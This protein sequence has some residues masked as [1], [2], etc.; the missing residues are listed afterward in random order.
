MILRRW[1]ASVRTRLRAAAAERELDDELRTHL[2]MAV[3]ENLAQGM[4]EREAARAAHR[5]L[6]VVSA[7]KEAYHQADSLYW[8]DTLL[9]DLRYGA[10][11]LRRSPRFTGAVVL[12]LGLG[13]GMTTAVFAIVDSVL[14]NAVPFAEPHRLVELYRLGP[15]GGGPG[16]PAAMVESWRNERALFDG[17]EAYVRLERVFTGG[18]EPETMQ[19]ARVSPGLL[20][21]LGVAP[22]LGRAF[23][24]DEAANAVAIVSHSTWLTR[25]GGDADIVGRPLRFTDGVLMIVGVMPASFRFPDA[26]TVFWEPLDVGRQAASGDPGEGRVSVVARLGRDVTFEQADARAAA[27]APQWNREWF[28]TGYTTRLK[29]LNQLAGLG[30]DGQFTWVQQRRAALFL[31][32]GLAA[33]VLLIACAN[34]ANLFLSQAL[35]RTREFAI[36]AAAG[37]GRLRLC[38]QLLTESV[39]V[40]AFAG[41]LG[42]TFA[43][44]LVGLAAAAVPPE[45]GRGV[46][47]PIDVD[48][49]VV[50]WA[51]VAAL[52]AGVAATLPPALR[53]VGRDL[54]RS[55]Q[56]SASDPARG[57]GRL[58]GGLVAVQNALAV[59]LLI[60]TL[61]MGRALWTLLDVDV[62]WTA[63]NAVAL[64]PRLAGTRYEGVEARSRFLEQLAALTAAVPG[65]EL[66]AP[67]E[68]VPSFASMISFGQLDTDDGGIAQAVVT[69]NYVPNRYFAAAEIPI[70]EGRGFDPDVSRPRL[71]RDA[72]FLEAD[73]RE[74]ALRRGPHNRLGFAYQV[75][76]VRVLG[77][78]PQQTPLEIDGEI[79][80]F[81]AL[82]LGAD[83]ETI[84]AYTRRRQTVSEHQQRIGEY[85]RLRAFDA[86]AGERL[87]RFLEDEALRLERTASL[88][89]RARAWLRDEHVLAP[90]DPVLRRAIGAARHKAR[91][92]LTQRMAERLSAPMREGLDALVAVDDDQPHSPLNRTSPR[93][94]GRCPRRTSTRPRAPS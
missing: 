92:L 65:V 55:M 81:A 77:R 84:H 90:S 7:V 35:S 43:G 83:A 39:L 75:A 69:T 79:L 17:V 36:R 2:E 31:L 48:G 24:P 53:T 70:L 10:R 54:I 72:T 85:L 63:E 86:A 71:V 56:G 87:A 80:R 73:R 62:G 5:D 27:L 41:L 91:T 9:Q 37:A 93:P 8:L 40:S 13:V 22:E 47:N 3:E 16:Q 49:R 94:A 89:A 12:V 29:S 68:Q 46:L 57:H 51:A 78:F 14:L 21:L 42:L 20:P 33:C 15:T 67:A 25:F 26:H 38:R 6:G 1:L 50:S 23:A 74:I 59:V 44:W 28:S 32:F 11:I 60:G 66:A 45:F 64:E 61:L 18:A 19:G 88:L 4:S 52:L 58:R 34:A 76:F 30:F 82:Q